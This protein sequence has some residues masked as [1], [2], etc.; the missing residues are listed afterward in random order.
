MLIL[1][2]KTFKISFFI[3]IHL[4][5]K[6]LM[7]V[8]GDLLWLRLIFN[9]LGLASQAQKFFCNDVFPLIHHKNIHVNFWKSP[10]LSMFK[11]QA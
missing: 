4:W 6:H 3:L 7:Y 5:K 2:L 8:I 10:K 11:F 1:Q 9:L